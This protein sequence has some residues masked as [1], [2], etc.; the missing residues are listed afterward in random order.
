MVDKNKE[1]YLFIGK[2]HYF[3]EYFNANLI[4][5]FNLHIILKKCVIKH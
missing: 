1:I 4:G 5:E 2:Y 3:I